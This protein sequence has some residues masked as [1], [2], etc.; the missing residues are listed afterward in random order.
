MEC[1]KQNDERILDI[2]SDYDAVDKNIFT[3]RNSSFKMC[4][5]NK[6]TLSNIIL[7]V[8]ELMSRKKNF[9]NAGFDII[10]TSESELTVQEIAKVMQRNSRDFGDVKI[11]YK[12]KDQKIIDNTIKGEVIMTLIIFRYLHG[13]IYQMK[14][15]EKLEDLMEAT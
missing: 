8:V 5:V 10:C 12:D 14:D 2:V 9:F 4:K 11:V 1:F 13:N 3:T 15:I 7:L 6:K